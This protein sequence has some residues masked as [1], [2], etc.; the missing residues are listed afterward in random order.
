MPGTY[1]K[2]KFDL[3]GFS[4]GIAES[5]KLLKKEFI[6]EKDVIIALP[7]SGLHSNGYSLVRNIIVKRKINIKK[8]KFLKTELLKPTK[9]YVK[10]ILNLLKKK[11]IHGCVHITGGG[12][13]GNMVRIIP[14]NMCAEIN[15]DKIKTKP[16]FKWLKNKGVSDKE[17]LKTFNCGIGF[18]IITKQKNVTKI[19][20]YFTSKFRPY[21]IGKIVK[22][23]K[24]R[25]LFNEKI[26]W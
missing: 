1:T 5:K 26:K 25:I 21:V 11:L 15:L 19:K 24:K 12:L 22:N 23:K 3:A 10:E 8:N 16:I 13:P 17:M 9:I 6:K 18:C 4:L 7:S 2:G 14:D 20:K